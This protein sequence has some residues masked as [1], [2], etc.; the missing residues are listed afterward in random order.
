MLLTTLISFR[1]LEDS[2]RVK[3]LSGKCELEGA[4]NHSSY[5]KQLVAS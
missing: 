4:S 3:H 2:S 1:V 5:K